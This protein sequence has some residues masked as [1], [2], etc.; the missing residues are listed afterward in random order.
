MITMIFELCHP[1]HSQTDARRNKKAHDSVEMYVYLCLM[2]M[3]VSLH[4]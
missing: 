3:F 2:Y 4:F 1:T